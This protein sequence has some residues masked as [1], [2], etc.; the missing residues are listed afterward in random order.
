MRHTTAQTIIILH[1]TTSDICGHVCIH[2]VRVKK[3]TIP[4]KLIAVKLSGVDRRLTVLFRRSE[5]P[6]IHGSVATALLK[7]NVRVHFFLNRA[8]FTTIN[9]S[10]ST[11][12][13]PVSRRAFLRDISARAHLEGVKLQGYHTLKKSSVVEKPLFWN[14]S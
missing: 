4:L 12:R 11:K 3:V 9:T 13:A 5:R 2:T 1:T 8:R 6:R 14:Y 10:R 7:N